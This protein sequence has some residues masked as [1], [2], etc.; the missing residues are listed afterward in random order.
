MRVRPEARPLSVHEWLPGSAEGLA[1]WHSN[2]RDIWSSRGSLG[3]VVKFRQCAARVL[4][5]PVVSHHTLWR[6]YLAGNDRY[7]LAGRR[8]LPPFHEYVSHAAHM[9]HSCGGSAAAEAVV[10]RLFEEK[11]MLSDNDE[12]ADQINAGVC[13]RISAPQQIISSAEKAKTRLCAVR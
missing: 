8:E 2:L 11:V 9:A 4:H 12:I 1:H 5:Y 6:R 10:R 3:K 13:E 7:T